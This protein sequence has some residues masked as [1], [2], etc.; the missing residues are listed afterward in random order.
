MNQQETSVYY[1]I[2]NNTTGGVPSKRH[3]SYES[4][5]EEARRLAKTN[6][7]QKFVILKAAVSVEVKVP[8]PTLTNLG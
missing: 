6:T 7:G 2:H 3:D 4:A 1:M 5:L 8:E